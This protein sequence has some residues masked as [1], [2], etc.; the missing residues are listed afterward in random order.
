MS[1][2]VIDFH[3]EINIT[4]QRIIIYMCELSRNLLSINLKTQQLTNK[5]QKERLTT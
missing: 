4:F 2:W 3:Q 5:T 1:V